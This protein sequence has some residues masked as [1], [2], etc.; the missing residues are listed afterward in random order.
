LIEP[1]E[2]ALSIDGLHW[3]LFILR[4]SRPGPAA[5]HAASGNARRASSQNTA[6]ASPG[7]DKPSA[8]LVPHRCSSVTLFREISRR[9]WRLRS[10]FAASL[11]ISSLALTARF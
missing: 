10:R 3:H 4:L 1:G 6:T 9:Y 7:R 8:A 11:V 2:L 5:C